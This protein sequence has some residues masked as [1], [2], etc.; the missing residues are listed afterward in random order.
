MK[1]N[2]ILAYR[3]LKD[4]IAKGTGEA[5]WNETMITPYWDIL[6]EWAPFP[7]D[8]RKPLCHMGKEEAQ[9][10]YELLEQIDWLQYLEVF[11]DICD[12][13]SKEDEDTLHI[14][15]YPSMTEMPE[16]IYGTSVWGNIILNINPLTEHFLDW[17]PFIF[18]HE[19]HHSV[20]GDYWYCKKGGE[21]L[22]DSFLQM[23]ITEGEAD[24]FAMS[25]Y[26]NLVPSWHKGV[27]QAE[28]KY[29]WKKI[30]SVMNEKMPIKECSKYMFGNKELGIPKNA[31]YY[32]AI[33]IINVFMENHKGMTIS[34][35]LTINP[36]EIYEEVNS[37][38]ANL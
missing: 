34:E 5:A 25:I 35:L 6:T 22:N 10:Q 19:Y 18:A 38:F 1:L 21:G 20:W 36:L 9:K 12:K 32:Y 27:S 2:L 28:E 30:K 8:Y 3:N 17:I 4:Y 37:I 11:K 16:G 13:L 23:M 26:K 24:A 31:G 14:A 29:V 7:M 15:I 33:K